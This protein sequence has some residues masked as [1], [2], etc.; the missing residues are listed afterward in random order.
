[1]AGRNE[2]SA[3]NRSM[4]AANE[5]V[6]NGPNPMAPPPIKSALGEFLRI[7][8]ES[9]RP[10]DVGLRRGPHRRVGGLRREEVAEL[11]ALSVDYVGRLER[12]N[13][14][15]PSTDVLA[16][17]ARGLRLTRAER[18]HLFVLAGRTV[19]S[20]PATEHVDAGLQRVLDRL[21]DTAAQ[22]L[23]PAGVTIRQTPL[24]VALVGDELA[25][26]GLDRSWVYR[27]FRRPGSRSLYLDE[28]H[29]YMGRATVCLLREDVLRYGP[30]SFAGEVLNA[31]RQA[32]VEFNDIWGRGE[33]GLRLS[34]EKRLIHPLVGRLDLYC[35]TLIEPESRLILLV[36]TATP[37]SASYERLNA[38]KV[39]GSELAERV[40]QGAAGQGGPLSRDK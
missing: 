40:D 1:V 36:Y 7:R 3:D 19:P 14:P 4:A 17:L 12:G 16:A 11:C 18:N 6:D 23:G 33:V 30:T 38:L 31:L 9:L 35:Q 2:L 8:R 28:D 22:V 39:M 32:S 13:G 37:G 20:H 21:Q 25:H 5:R 29:D 10:E 15:W 26:E 27:W 24:D 34:A